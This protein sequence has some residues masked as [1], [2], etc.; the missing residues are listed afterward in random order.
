[1]GLRVFPSQTGSGSVCLFSAFFSEVAEGPRKGTPGSFCLGKS[2]AV[3]ALRGH[4]KGPLGTLSLPISTQHWER[5]D[6]PRGPRWA[7]STG[8]LCVSSVCGDH[9][10]SQQSWCPGSGVSV[11]AEWE[12]REQASGRRKVSVLTLVVVTVSKAVKR[13]HLRSVQ[14]EFC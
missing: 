14:G 10:Q 2:K 4:D 1:M 7:P 9:A 13:P 8:S 5:K 12:G 11:Q 6:P 3:V